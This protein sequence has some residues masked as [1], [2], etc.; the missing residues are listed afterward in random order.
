M[1][2]SQ[3][4][5]E[6]T[7]GLTITGVTPLSGGDISQAFRVDTPDASYFLKAHQNPKADV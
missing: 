6:L 3:L 2:Y 4:P 7:D 5:A 1:H